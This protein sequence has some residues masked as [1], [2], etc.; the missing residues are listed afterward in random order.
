VSAGLQ[1][2]IAISNF[3]SSSITKDIKEDT[4]Q[5]RD[6]TDVIKQDTSQLK[7]DTAQILDEI[8]RLRSQLPDEVQHGRNFILEQYLDNLTGYAE[9]VIADDQPIGTEG[10]RSP[11]AV[12]SE[13]SSDVDSSEPAASLK[14]QARSASTKE[15]ETNRA[16]DTVQI[17]V[18]QFAAL[19]VQCKSGLSAKSDKSNLI[20]EA[21]PKPISKAHDADG[22]TA[23]KYEAG[24]RGFMACNV[25]EGSYDRERG[26]LAEYRVVEAHEKEEAQELRE[27]VIGEY[28]AETGKIIEV[29]GKEKEEKAAI[30]AYER[31]KTEY[32]KI[33]EEIIAQVKLEEEE[34]RQKENEEKEMWKTKFSK[35]KEE[36]EEEEEEKERRRKQNEEREYWKAKIEEEERHRQP[37]GRKKVLSI[38]R[39]ALP[40]RATDQ[41]SYSNSDARTLVFGENNLITTEARTSPL[42]LEAPVDLRNRR[43]SSSSSVQREPQ[44]QANQPLDQTNDGISNRTCPIYPVKWRHVSLFKGNLILD[45]PIPDELLNQIPHVSPPERDEFTHYRY[46]LVACEPENYESENYI[47]RPK[48]LV[49]PRKAGIVLTVHPHEQVANVALSDPTGMAQSVDS[50]MSGISY[51]HALYKHFTWKNIFVCVMINDLDRRQLRGSWLQNLGLG[52]VEKD[53]VIIYDDEYTS[54]QSYFRDSDV[55]P[56]VNGKLVKAHMY[57]V[58]W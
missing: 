6:D 30:E 16:R 17:G 31:E 48:L 27:A 4:G 42:Q 10:R 58:S 57:E 28:L 33:R 53:T 54:A 45:C 35:E 2:T 50:I 49:K 9:S 51:L 24:K 55:D 5:I 37:K 19:S 52:L 32:E 14:V 38:P 13:S 18:D 20:P 15:V 34:R 44:G 25:E 29:W 21:K 41:E 12:I 23:S 8:A 3:N 56:M 11:P 39:R 7:M 1:T 26:I 47:L 22:A 40:L 43:S 36:E 46:S